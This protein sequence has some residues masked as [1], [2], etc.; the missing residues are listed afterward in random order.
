[1]RSHSSIVVP[2]RGGKFR[3]GELKRRN[4]TEKAKSVKNYFF[5]KGSAPS[6]LSRRA[7]T[8]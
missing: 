2:K 1:M 8:I 7:V 3:V 6:G 4:V 5:A